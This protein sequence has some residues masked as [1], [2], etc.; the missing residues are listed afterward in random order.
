MTKPSEPN[1]LAHRSSRRT[2]LRLATLAAAAPV[3][4]ATAGV[5]QAGT[6]QSS[7][8]LTSS[9]AQ[10]VVAAM[11]PGW[12]LGNT[13]DAI[14][15]DET[16]WG[17]PPVTPALIR[18]I[19][20]E[21]FRSMRIPVT[22]EGRQGAG[23]DYTIDPAWLTKVK[24]TVDQVLAKGMYA[25]I[26]LHHDSWMWIWDMPT[27]YDTVL[28][29][30]NATWTQLAD[31]FRDY[32]GRLLF[33]SVNEPQFRGSSGQAEDIQLLH[34]LNVS[35]HRI[36]RQSGGRNATR[37]LVLPTLNTGADQP[38]VDG[39]VETF[40]RL[41]D[42]NLV[43]TTHDYSFWPF[44]VNI[45]GY[46]RYTSEVQDWHTSDWD[47]VHDAFTA[48]GIPV[49][50]G[51]YGLLSWDSN[52]HAVE[53]GEELKFFEFF[54]YYARAKQFTTMVW[55]NGGRLDRASYQWRDPD[56]FTQIKSSWTTRS[57]TVSD[58][59]VFTARSAAI[60]DKTL[61]LNLNGTR[62]RELRH[63][64]RPLVRGRDY[65]VSGD[66]LTV[67]AAALTRLSGDR[68]YGVNAALH[69]HFSKG[70]PWRIDVTAYDTPILGDATGTTD[71]FTIPTQFRG[72][73]LATMEAT[74]VDDGA[75]AGPHNWTS[76]KEFEITFT[77]DYPSS[78]IRLKPAFF[79][80]V[81]DDRPVTL[82]FHF[83]SGA[84][85]TY[86]VTKSGTAVTGTA[87]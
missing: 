17:N 72:D 58:D 22:W 64:R 25:M 70:V 60:T 28:A 83:W 31:T 52:D 84:K 8:A 77:P 50:I 80:E 56:L 71:E 40:K 24:K 7:A 68:A 51:E 33:E 79:A 74:Y 27:Q 82:T 42:P 36:V 46:T 26:N 15:A 19:R 43:A 87:G 14:G 44:S 66:Q 59:F 23:P 54:G 81:A 4:P 12:N 61:T 41:D 20:S 73:R 85:L 65:T 21:G 67:T 69:A 16:A 47:R 75:N 53:R 62:F 32:S 78:L 29:R 3:I 11:Q 86:R 5:A 10:R 34:E 18:N 37:L 38:R 6:A 1:P 9:A 30:F 76:F 35:F 63:G 48:N 2:V 49:I 39:L 55:D 45:A 57:G 13:Y